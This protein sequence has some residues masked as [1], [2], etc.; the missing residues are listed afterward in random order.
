[1]KMNEEGLACFKAAVDEI[2]NR[3][4]GLKLAV[5]HMGGRNGQQVSQPN[6]NKSIQRANNNC[7]SS[8]TIADRHRDQELCV[9]VLHRE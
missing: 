3:W 2:F 1:M 7:L 4:T 9:R 5:E 6:V 8:D